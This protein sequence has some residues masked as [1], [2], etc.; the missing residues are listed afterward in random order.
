MNPG[1]AIETA[2]AESGSRGMSCDQIK[3][4]LYLPTWIFELLSRKQQIVTR[5]SKSGK[6][7]MRSA[8]KRLVRLSQITEGYRC[9]VCYSFPG[10]SEGRIAGGAAT[11][12]GD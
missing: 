11:E 2:R 5:E 6:C 9:E 12:M 4:E 7:M 10:E 8:F 3:E 1:I